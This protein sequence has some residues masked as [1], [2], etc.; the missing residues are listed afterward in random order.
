MGIDVSP[1][2]TAMGEGVSLFKITNKAGASL[3]LTNFGATAVQMNMP[4]PDGEI[5]D[6]VLGFVGL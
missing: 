6:V 1:W 3:V 4:S 5:A 2:G